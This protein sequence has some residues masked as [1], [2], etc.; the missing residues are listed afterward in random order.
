M[1]SAVR[2]MLQDLQDHFPKQM[3]DMYQSNQL[4]FEDIVSE[5]KELFKEQI[6]EANDNICVD[7]GGNILN[8]EQYY[9]ETF[10]NEE[11]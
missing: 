1:K 5:A 11:R 6:I 8:A 3:K 4:L 9:N 7:G 2:K 10:K